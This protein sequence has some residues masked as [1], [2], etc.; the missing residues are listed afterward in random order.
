MHVYSYT[1]IDL[2]I[3]LRSPEV[4]WKVSFIYTLSMAIST[5]LNRLQGGEKESNKIA[6]LTPES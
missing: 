2:L 5:F 6:C 1:N 3:I 4:G